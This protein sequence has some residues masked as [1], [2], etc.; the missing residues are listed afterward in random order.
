LKLLMALT[1]PDYLQ[2]IH[3]DHYMLKSVGKLGCEMGIPFD[4]N[5]IGE[6]GRVLELRPTQVVLTDDRVTDKYLLVD[7]MSV[8]SVSELVLAERRQM[9][10]QGVI[11]LVLLI[12]KKKELTA[13]PEII[14]RGFVYMKSSTA[15]FDDIKESVREQFKHLDI[16]PHSASYFSELRQAV[17]TM[18]SQ[19]VFAITEKE[20]VIIPVVVQ[21]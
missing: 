9:A 18:V 6:N 17:K 20:P 4:H 1:K 7:G 5:L 11:M 16:D 8:G 12:N 2:P 13:G 15:L 10:A 21:L 3:G 19:K 14:S